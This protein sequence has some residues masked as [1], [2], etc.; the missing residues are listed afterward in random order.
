MGMMYYASMYVH[1]G[2]SM[3]ELESIIQ[4]CDKT[5]SDR[6]KEGIRGI[7][8]N[9]FVCVEFRLADLQGFLPQI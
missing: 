5:T 1:A 7:V 9:E 2:A 6:G 4:E 8:Y 3:T